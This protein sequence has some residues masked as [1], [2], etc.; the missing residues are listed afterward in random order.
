V[1]QAKIYHKFQSKYIIIIHGRQ[2]QYKHFDQLHAWTS[3]GVD[4]ERTREYTSL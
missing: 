4:P 2:S 1:P 3:T